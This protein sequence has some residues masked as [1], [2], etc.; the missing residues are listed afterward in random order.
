MDINFVDTVINYDVPSLAKTYV[1]RCGRT[2]RGSKHGTAISLLKGGQKSLF[3]RMR[4]LIQAPDRIQPR[5]VQKQLVRD[6]FRVYRPCMKALRDVL[7][8]EENGELSHTDAL[9]DYVP[10]ATAT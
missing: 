8:A 2:A 3:Q 4:R 6:A 7:D 10:D 9:D 1:H 5:A